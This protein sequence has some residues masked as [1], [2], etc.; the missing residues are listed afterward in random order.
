MPRI[1][2]RLREK[3]AWI[4][5]KERRQRFL[6][7]PVSLS[8][9]PGKLIYNTSGFW[10]RVRARALR[11]PIFLSSLPPQTGRCAPPTPSIAASLLLIGPPKI[12]KIYKVLTYEEE[13]RAVSGVFQNIDPPP[14]FHP[15]G[16]SSPAPK[17]GGTHSPG[18]ATILFCCSYL[19]LFFY[20]YLFLFLSSYI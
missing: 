10:P 2:M 7:H 6:V 15:A 11:A 8:T 14:P 12:Y 13:Y 4:K 17:A 19:F 18:S 1:F 3:N 5:N 20:S 16:V 9:S